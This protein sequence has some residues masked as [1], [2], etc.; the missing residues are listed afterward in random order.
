M[1]FTLA[2]RRSFIVLSGCFL[3]SNIALA[4]VLAPDTTN[5]T[6]DDDIRWAL[7]RTCFDCHSG[8]EARGGLLLDSYD[9]LMKGGENGP[10]VVPGS[11]TKSI[12]YQKI[13][14][15]PPFG[16]MM[17]RKKDLKLSDYEI[18]MIRTWIESGARRAHPTTKPSE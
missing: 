14:P 11:P 13:L 8:K 1:I 4:Q 18:E 16:K 12:L 6:Y 2:L 3:F 5:L 10:S 17:P 9:A 7:V 15:D